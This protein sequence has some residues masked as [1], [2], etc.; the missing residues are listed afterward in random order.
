MIMDGIRKNPQY[1]EVAAQ[2]VVRLMGLPNIP[3]ALQNGNGL[4]GPTGQ[5][6]ASPLGVPSANPAPPGSPQENAQAGEQLARGL[7]GQVANPSRVGQN[8]TGTTTRGAI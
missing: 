8:R 1:L 7:T 2:E 6:L 5:P 4:V 3:G